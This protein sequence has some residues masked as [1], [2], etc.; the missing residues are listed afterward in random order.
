MS[1]YGPRKRRAKFFA[2]LLA[3]STLLALTA[4]G[5]TSPDLRPDDSKMRDA[6]S[7]LIKDLIAHHP[8]N[9]NWN[10]SAVDSQ[11]KRALPKGYSTPAGWK[12]TWAGASAEELPYV[13][14]PW[15]LLGSY[16]N[17]FAADNAT[18]SSGSSVPTTVVK[19]LET[20]LFGVDSYFAAVVDVKY[21]ATDKSWIIFTTVPYLPVTDNAYG[22]A[23]AINRHWKVVDFG[24]ALV[25]CGKVPANVQNEYG[26][27]CPNQ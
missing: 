4:C 9:K 2:L 10:Q 17:H 26:F 5:P 1:F 11:L 21:S 22:W 16:P 15:S 12:L 14:I 24:T 8:D 27:S 7:L 20:Q 23:N 18:Y 3:S 13:Y 19:S 25:G 6:I